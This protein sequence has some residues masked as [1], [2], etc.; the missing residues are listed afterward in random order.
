MPGVHKMPTRDHQRRAS[1]G[2][3][4][5][6]L[7]PRAADFGPDASEADPSRGLGPLRRLLHDPYEQNTQP[8][9]VVELRRLLYGLYAIMR[10]H[11]AQED[12]NAFSLIPR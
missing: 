6:P 2:T 8:E 4:V 3:G 5:G 9:D 10:L 11:N 12:E 1:S 7:G